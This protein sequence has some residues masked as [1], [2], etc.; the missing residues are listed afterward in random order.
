MTRTD[1]TH[2]L[3][4]STAPQRLP[5]FKYLCRKRRTFGHAYKTNKGCVNGK[6]HDAHALYPR[7]KIFLG[8]S[9]ITI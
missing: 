2:N 7:I 8:S 1:A 9:G 3:G 5:G 6:F 4:T